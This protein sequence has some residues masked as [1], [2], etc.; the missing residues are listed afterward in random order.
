MTLLKLRI[1]TFFINFLIS[2]QTFGSV[3]NPWSGCPRDR[4]LR[5]DCPTGW[6][7]FDTNCYV[8]VNFPLATFDNARSDCVSRGAQLL[9]IGNLEEHQFIGNWLEQNSLDRSL[10]WY[11]SGSM[12]MSPFGE[13]V[14][15]GWPQTMQSISPTLYQL[16][17]DQPPKPGDMPSFPTSRNKLVY[18]T[19]GTAW[20]WFI[21]TATVAR[22]FICQALVQNAKNLRP[23]GRT[24]DFGQDDTVPISRGPCFVDQPKD[25]WFVTGIV[26]ENF[27]SFNCY[28][29]GNPTPNYRW[30]KIGLM[31][32]ATGV[33]PRRT[34]VEPLNS[35]TGRISTSGG[36][37]VIQNPIATLDSEYYQCEAYNTFGSIL[38]RT[39]KI[40]FGQLE[41][42]PKHPRRTRKAWAYQSVTLPCD[43]PAHSPRDSL[44]YSFYMRKGLSLEPVVLSARPGV[45]VSQAQAL[46]GFSEATSQDSGVY[47]CMITMYQ[48]GSRLSDSPKSPD[49][50]LVVMESNQRTQEPRI[51]DSF[52]SIWPSDP[53]RGHSV[54]IE[55]FA[56]GSVQSGPLQYAWRRLDGIA[57]PSDRLKELN[58]VIEIPQVQPED[59]GVYEC[60]VT[61]S[62]GSQAQ[63]RT[64]SLRIKAVPYFTNMAKDEIVSVGDTVT[65]VCEAQGIPEPSQFWY[66]NGIRVSELI[67]TSVLDATRYRLQDG[68]KDPAS[69]VI[70][71][72]VAG[73]SA[74]FDCLAVNSLG[75]VSSSG[76]LRVLA[77]APTFQKNPMVPVLGMVGQSTVMTCQPEAAP[78]PVVSWFFQGSPLSP[79]PSVID[80]ST[81]ETTCP[82][83]YCTLPSGNLLIAQLTRMQE[84]LYE[85]RAQ[86]Q[87]GTAST[88]AHLTVIDALS[89][90]LQPQNIIVDVNSTVI[91]PC[92]AIVSSFLDVNYAWFYED[93]EIKFDRLDLDARRYDKTQ[94]FRPYDRDFGFLH[95]INIQLYDAGRYTCEAQTPLS[96]NRVTAYV[97]V[98]GPPGPCAGVEASTIPDTE[99]VMVNWTKGADH[100]HPI[101]YYIIE[102]KVADE[103]WSVVVARLDESPD[104]EIGQSTNRRTTTIGNLYSNILYHLRVLAANAKGVGEPSRPSR[105]II[106]LPKAPTKLVQNVTGGGGKQGTLV[107]RWEPLPYFEHN[108]DGFHYILRWRA[109]EDTEFTEVHVYDPPQVWNSTMVQHTVSL[110]VERFYKPY[111]V[112]IQAVNNQGV[113]PVTDPVIIMSAARVPT[114]APRNQEANQYNGSA[115]LIKW[116]PPL[117]SG[118][119][120]PLLGYRLIY[121]RR[122]EECLGLESDIERFEQGQRRTLYGGDLTSGFIIGLEQDIYYCVAVQAFNT[123]GDSPPSGFAEQ[124]TYKLWPQSFPTMVQLNSTRYPRTVR[125]SWIGV[126]TTLNEEAV[127]GYRIR[128]WL[129]G[130]NYKEAHTD[131]D[132]RMR[133]Y[134]YIQNLEINKRYN[135]RVYAYSRAGVGKMSSPIVQFQMIPR[136][137]C[138]PGASWEGPDIHYNLV[139]SALKMHSSP[140]TVFLIIVLLLRQL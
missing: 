114:N 131:V 43:P 1:Q 57:I 97:L 48:L 23:N 80:P 94:F 135:L 18:G 95:I 58:R 47:V 67:S 17:F 16:W 42:F 49:M 140:L 27:V 21:D 98:A 63:P 99:L 8:F 13:F 93:V 64:V 11:T 85:C 31:S 68:T 103:P 89:I 38:S 77:F 130:A 83:T 19:N 34:L 92:K 50:P 62:M 54:R 76:E 26:V 79:V 73:D 132:V 29:N 123:A 35:T 9:R 46:I 106:T 69:L 82:S 55:C 40:V 133:T 59:Q 37:L 70:S 33:V 52:P 71:N 128:Y 60:S 109:W 39:A 139:C 4:Q 30:Y 136:D 32:S 15:S 66:R 72:V 14:W 108:G 3:I 36:N 10:R 28:A 117:L 124:T 105:G 129:V 87:F 74:M 24:I 137:Q 51:Y 96:R 7:P 122:N 115:L 56:G 44:I 84:G 5:S 119:E 20:G 107:V 100:L 88:S 110:P 45:F 6:I 75:S 121:W 81:G 41:T 101:L 22:P 125:V 53:I 25:V 126:Q 112:T 134:G 91:V 102:A 127:L 104:I 86:N 61:D 90:S 116:A 138:V 78:D 2:L 111:E 65:M 120:G 118:D 12:L 113:G